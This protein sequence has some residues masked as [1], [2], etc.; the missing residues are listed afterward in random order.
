MNVL[1]VQRDTMTNTK[2]TKCLRPSSAQT[3]E[4]WL[5]SALF[6]LMLK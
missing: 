2:L 1:K 5:M 6:F 4:R 3:R